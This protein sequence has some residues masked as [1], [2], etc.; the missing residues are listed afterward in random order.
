MTHIG[1]SNDAEHCAVELS[2]LQR[3]IC[4]CQLS[5]ILSDFK[6]TSLTCLRVAFILN[7]YCVLRSPFALRETVA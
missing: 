4:R 6:S 5:C 1:G 2:K 7:V 3:L